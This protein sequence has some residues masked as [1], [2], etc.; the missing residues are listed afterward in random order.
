LIDCAFLNTPVETDDDQDVH[1]E[2]YSSAMFSIET[3]NHYK[4][5]AVGIAK[6][7]NAAEG[8]HFGLQALF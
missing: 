5:G 2:Y 1:G 8:W 6:A 7:T 3:W 4:A